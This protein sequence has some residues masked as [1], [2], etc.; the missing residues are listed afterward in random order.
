MHAKVVIDV[1]KYIG[2]C[3]R[4][5]LNAPPSLLRMELSYAKG[6]LIGNQ[7]FPYVVTGFRHSISAPTS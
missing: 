4:G 7:P 5:C 6:K 2:C 1:T 3:A